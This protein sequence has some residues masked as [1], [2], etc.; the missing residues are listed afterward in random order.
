MIYDNINDKAIG[1]NLWMLK[2][3]NKI[4][5][6]IYIILG[7]FIIAIYSLL[8]MNIIL[9]VESNKQISKV[10][11]SILRNHNFVT[12]D[13]YLKSVAPVNLVLESSGA[14]L[15]YSDKY[16]DFYALVKNANT[17]YI[18]DY[19]DYYF[20]YDGTETGI[21]RDK[22]NIN[23]EKFLFYTGIGA[24]YS[25]NLPTVEFS[26][27]DIGWKL[28][29][30]HEETVNRYANTN[31]PKGCIYLSNGLKAKNIT[32]TRNVEPI[33]NREVN[34]LSFD[35]ENTSL[36]NYKTINNKI[37][38]YNRDNAIIGIFQKELYLLNSDETKSLAINLSP[39]IKD[40]TNILI[41]PEI[42]L[43]SEDSFISK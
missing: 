14:V 15:G 30:K 37:I 32:I 9:L 18:A 35:I 11:D 10:Y 7:L 28:V 16:Y 24:G 3:I 43:C 33:T 1:I 26:V 5:L 19:V 23:S 4:R 40:V 20:K 25:E 36:Y 29:S 13:S 6:W 31:V 42:D 34:V 21:K 8:V 2:N 27:K 12:I 38:F 22:I 39:N 17:N 41:V